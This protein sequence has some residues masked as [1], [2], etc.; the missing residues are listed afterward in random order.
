MTKVCIAATYNFALI[1][2]Y[3][4]IIKLVRRGPVCSIAPYKLC[5]FVKTIIG[6]GVVQVELVVFVMTTVRFS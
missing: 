1:N 5:S 3:K 2:Y 4:L 6:V